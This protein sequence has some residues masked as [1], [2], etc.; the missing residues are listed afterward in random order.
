MKK[1]LLAS[2]AVMASAAAFGQ[3]YNLSI[4][5]TNGSKVVIPT[6]DISKIE[7]VEQVTPQ[8][9]TADLLDIV[10]KED[11]TAEDVS[12]FHHTVITSRGA[13]LMTYYNENQKR[14]VASFR[15]SI[16][17]VASDGHY[18][19]NYTAGD[20]FIS[21]I[22]DGCTFETIM[23]LGEPDAPGKEVKWFSS[24]QAGGIGF[25]LP[26]HSRTKCITFLP[27]VSQNGA[28]N[29]CWTQSSVV[30]QPGRYYHVVGVWN[31]SEGKSYIYVNG[32]LSGTA[33]AK[34]NYVPV[35]GGAESFVIGGDAEP[36]KTKAESAWNGDIAM[37][38]IYDAPYTASQVAE[39]WEN[40]KFDEDQTLVTISDLQYLPECEVGAGYRYTVFGKGFSAGDKIELQSSGI[41][42]ISP[43]T[44]VSDGSA[45]IVIPA[46][47]PS[48]T[49]KLVL[50]RGT[51]STPLCSVKFTYAANPA[52][53]LMPKIVAHR[54][55]HA[56]G[57]TENSLQALRQAM[58]ANYYGIELDVWLTS[59]GRAVVHHDGVASGDTFANST[60]DQIQNI[61]L[62]NGEKLP[63]L[64]SYLTTF[65]N[66]MNES[67]SKLIVEIKTH[68]QLDRTLAAV[69]ATM[70]MID[71]MGLK[72]RVEYIAFSYDACKHIV[73]KQPDAI[74]GYL[75]GDRAPAGVLADGIK[76]ID[77]SSGA[78]A[79]HPEWISQ[80]RNLGMIVNVWTVNTASE[81]LS[82]I[83]KGVHYITTD[84]PATL[85][86]LTTKKFVS[87][88]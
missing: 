75:S 13:N 35:Q 17:D 4:S 84:A 19:V 83:G 22:A 40:A 57:A 7:F 2:V 34:G 58:D 76:S 20:N 52:A 30:P 43:E 53:P 50:R 41:D 81:M 64:E 25:L 49:Y 21:R 27:N 70:A 69:D 72:S 42:N 46:S 33:A 62:A 78:L 73:S 67:S 88:E 87:A 61:T 8:S 54:G 36:T 31:K 6:E 5:K 59:D 11:G 10:F 12:P 45:T 18:R 66:K 37:V 14:Y 9:P 80:A 51:S 3:A 39:L 1:L 16:G 68:P 29:W 15:H 55:A 60:Y 28:S 32:E 47:M 48:G 71:E 23:M 44:I 24:M 82:F 74:V 85:L 38:R 56:G 79:G 26:V 86:E 77:Y 65:K 63:T